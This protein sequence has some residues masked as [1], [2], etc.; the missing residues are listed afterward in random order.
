MIYQFIPYNNEIEM[1]NLQFI[2]N[3]DIVD[4]FIISESNTTYSGIPKKYNF[5]DQT[6]NL[7]KYLDKVIYDPIKTD[8]INDLPE[9]VINSA[10]DLYKTNWKRE[11]KQRENFLKNHHFNDNDI[12]I[13]TDVDEIVFLKDVIDKIDKNTLNY[14]TIKHCRY[15]VNTQLNKND[16]IY[17]KITCFMYKTYVEKYKNLSEKNHSIR[18]I[19]RITGDYLEHDDCGYH[20]SACYDLRE[21]LQSFSHGEWNNDS[22]YNH[23]INEKSSLTKDNVIEIPEIILNN[24]DSKFI[25][26]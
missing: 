18:T 25:Y 5:Y 6:T 15:Y 14:F 12:L 7:K 4:R 13:F 3:Y 16:K 23:V 11:Y 8:D 10:H 17:K 1:L 24:I 26:F 22:C 9:V 2:I 19:G 21:K 20:L